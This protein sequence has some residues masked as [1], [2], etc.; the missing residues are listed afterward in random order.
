MDPED[1]ELI[2]QLFAAATAEAEGAA[3]IAAE[4]QGDKANAADY[5]AAAEKLRLR[6]QALC[7]LCEA[8]V[9]LTRR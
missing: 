7:A 9:L 5:R 8:I 4:G 3:E 2:R 1:R 6:A